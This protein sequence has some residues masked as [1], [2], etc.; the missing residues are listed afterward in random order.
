MNRH[1]GFIMFQNEDGEEAMLYLDSISS[2]CKGIHTDSNK[3]RG[4]IH[5]DSG[6]IYVSPLEYESTLYHVQSGIDIRPIT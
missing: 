3:V 2:V 4:E 6:K 1:R 5:M